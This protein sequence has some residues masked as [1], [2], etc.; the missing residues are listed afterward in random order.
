[1]EYWKHLKADKKLGGVLTEKM[2]PIKPGKEP[3][4]DLI[5]SIASQQLSVKAAETIFNR[6]LDQLG[7]DKFNYERIVRIKDDDLRAVGFSYQK[8]SYIKN[9]ARFHCENGIV[10]KDLKKLNNQEVIDYLT[11][12]K[13]VGQWTVEMLLIFSLAREDVFSSG[14]LGIQQAMCKLYKID[15]SDKKKMR[16]KMEKIAESWSPFRSY[17]CRHLWRFKDL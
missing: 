12:I 13:G 7:D 14:D 6:F 11:Q 2:P 3:A 4:M 16:L 8:A 1:M 9:V 5:R 10:A 17:A 15:S